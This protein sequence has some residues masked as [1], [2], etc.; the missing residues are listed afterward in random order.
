MNSFANQPL[1]LVVFQ[2]CRLFRMS[3]NFT[4]SVICN[5]QIVQLNVTQRRIYEPNFTLFMRKEFLSFVLFA[6]GPLL[7]CE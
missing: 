7:L 1:W 3:A 2:I 5:L 6:F 4:D